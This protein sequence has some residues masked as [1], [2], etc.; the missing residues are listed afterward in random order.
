MLDVA[1]GRRGADRRRP[2]AAARR[3]ARC[4]RYRHGPGAFKVDF[5]VEGGVPW[6][7]EP[8][9]AAPA[10]STSAAAFEEIAA[11]ERDGRAAGGC[12]SGR[13][14][15]SA[16]STSPTRPGRSGDV[17]PLYAY[18]HVPAG[19]T[20]DATA[21]IEAQIERFAPGFRDRILARARPHRRRRWRRTTPTTSAATSS[22]ARTRALQ[23]IFRP[24]VALD[25][26]ATGHPGRLPV[27]GGDAAGRRRARHVRLQ[28]RRIRRSAISAS[29]RSTTHLPE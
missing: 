1:P 9:A 12:P 21:A 18:A 10:P 15:S 25:P 16:S 26:Y 5:A 14:C 4:R 3:A 23:L 24:R 6:T 20:G 11:A 29:S 19:Y 27:L 28:R 2:D 13:S 22:P 17:H 7:H 8:I